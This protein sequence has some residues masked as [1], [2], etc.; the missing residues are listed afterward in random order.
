[1]KGEMLQFARYAKGLI[2]SGIRIANTSYES[3]LSIRVTD[4][5]I[6][7]LLSHISGTFVR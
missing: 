6:F 4:F 1:M 7:L 3:K 5:Q 2:L